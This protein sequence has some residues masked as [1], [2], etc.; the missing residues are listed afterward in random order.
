[1]PKIELYK[2][3]AFGSDQA[4]KYKRFAIAD[5]MGLGKTR[6]GLSVMQRA[7]SQK[8]L[9]ICTKN[10]FV[11]WKVQCMEWM[12]EMEIIYVRGNKAERRKQ[13][14]RYKTAAGP[15]LFIMTPACVLNDKDEMPMVWD[16]IELDEYDRFMSNRSKTWNQVKKL[17]SE[18]LIPIS[19]SPTRRGPQNLWPLF[20]LIDPKKFSSY[21]RF[22]EHFTNVSQGRFG[23]EIEGIQNLEELRELRTRYMVR[24]Y[25]K[26]VIK[27]LPA[28]NR[29]RLMVE[30]LPDQKRIYKQIKNDM[31][32]IIQD[33]F[34]VVANIL[35]QT[36]RLRQLLCCPK[37]L[38]PSL[39]DGGALDMIIDKMKTSSDHSVIFVPFI[40][41]IPYV[42]ARL[43]KEGFGPITILQGGLEPNE[44]EERVNHFKSK[45]GVCIC[46]VFYA[47][48]FELDTSEYGYFLGFA[49]DP[50]TNEQ[51]EDRL[52]RMTTR[53]VVNMAYLVHEG[54]VDVDMLDIVNEKHQSI[55][56]MFGS[57]DFVK[58]LLNSS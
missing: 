3:Q 5:Q 47:Q 13:W 22:V 56:A 29:Y 36:I 41:A 21:W 57:R 16:V 33:E 35:E 4:M 10:A 24:H 19:G 8:N 46:S 44:L 28:K 7:Q 23:R 52:H 50:D 11:T 12:P 55:E 26:D 30:M 40:K 18:Y 6:T 58:N 14:A 15:Q 42:K 54:C 20:N 39:S 32:T 2:Y 53:W 45:G 43:E 25:K 31:L 48:S 27:E 51:A 49:Y 38:D 9:M 34:Y 37:I 1:M 17:K